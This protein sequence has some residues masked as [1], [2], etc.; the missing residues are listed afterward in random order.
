LL[1]HAEVDGAR[2]RVHRLLAVGLEEGPERDLGEHHALGERLDQA[3]I[4][5]LLRFGEGARLHIALR[6]AL[7]GADEVAVGRLALREHQ[8]DAYHYRY[9]N[10]EEPEHGGQYTDRT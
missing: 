2:A 8:R 4:E 5:L 6:R 3:P 7:I 9:T 1:R 10:E